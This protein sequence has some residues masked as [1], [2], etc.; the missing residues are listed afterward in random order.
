M[1]LPVIALF[2][3]FSAAASPAGFGQSIAPFQGVKHVT[4]WPTSIGA[5]GSFG[6][7]DSGSFTPDLYPDV[8]QLDGSQPVL[9][10]D[11]DLGF[12][13]IVIPVSANDVATLSGGHPAG[14]DAVAVVSA[15]GLE[16]WWWDSGLSGLVSQSLNT[17]TWAGAGTVRTADL[18]ADGDQ[19]LYGVAADG[20]TVLTLLAGSGG[21]YVAGS[22][23][24]AP[25]AVDALEAVLWD[26]DAPRELAVMTALGVEVRELDGTL[27]NT[28]A[29]ALPGGALCV[30]GQSGQS[31]ERLAW[32][33]DH[34]GSGCQL[35]MTLSPLGSGDIIDLG[36]LGAVAMVP[37]DYDLDGDDDVLISH[38]YSYDLLRIE[39]QRS[40]ANPTGPTF[41]DDP[42]EMQTFYADTPGAAPQNEAWP[43]IADLDNDGDDDVAFAGEKYE[44]Y[45]VFRGEAVL[46]DDQC[47]SVT[48]TEYVVTSPGSHGQL[49]LTL[50]A[51]LT[52]D[53]GAT[54]L[55][56][57]VRRQASSTS[58]M[59]SLAVGLQSVPLPASWPAPISIQIPEGDCAFTAAYH[60]EI[61]VVE[62]DAGGAVV[63]AYPTHISTFSLLGAEVDAFASDEAVGAPRDVPAPTPQGAEFDPGILKRKR[64]KVYGPGNP[65]T[66]PSI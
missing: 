19:D 34:T 32:I 22:S 18:D 63:A 61:R 55:E 50:D 31:Q 46:E 64:I 20:I 29:A 5:S 41:I 49:D 10:V 66:V 36:T 24:V 16:L 54:D 33:T 2:L 28:F 65:P 7:A 58:D 12:A 45:I 51:P 9:L 62:R 13:P 4:D 8:V 59:D 48:P 43:V 6:R 37:T 25:T 26:A 17:T 44:K 35:L 38:R 57:V 15:A 30:L 27:I 23:F 21:S 39:N 56:I 47:V 52:T 53:P 60:I 40:P 11:I 1:R 14:L 3:G 42:S